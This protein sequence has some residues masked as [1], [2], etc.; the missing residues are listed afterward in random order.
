MIPKVPRQPSVTRQ[1]PLTITPRPLTV[2][3]WPLN[4][5][6]TSSLS[7]NYYSS[8]IGYA[9]SAPTNP[10][11]SNIGHAAS[12]ITTGPYQPNVGSTTTTI[13]AGPIQYGVGH[14]LPT[15]TP[16]PPQVPTH[17]GPDPITMKGSEPLR[18]LPDTNTPVPAVPVPSL[19]TLSE[20]N[21]QLQGR[22][23]EL[24]NYIAP[25]YWTNPAQLIYSPSDD[26]QMAIQIYKMTQGSA[27]AP[28]L[29]L[30]FAFFNRY[31]GEVVHR[32]YEHALRPW[33]P[34]L[35]SH[36]GEPVCD[37]ES[38][39]VPAILLYTLRIYDS[40]MEK[41]EFL[42]DGL[43]RKGIRDKSRGYDYPSAILQ[44]ISPYR[45]EIGNPKYDKVPN[46]ADRINGAGPLF[47][48]LLPFECRCILGESR[49]AIRISQI[50][51][52]YN[53]PTVPPTHEIDSIVIDS[54]TPLEPGQGR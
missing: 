29:M 44:I 18:P 24:L 16:S 30:P 22:L 45:V 32:T 31:T 14:A 51:L 53:E 50:N 33:D 39:V 9:S 5:T 20:V 54:N 41:M 21:K 47:S 36:P 3:A 48:I 19:S 6:K 8:K 23:F 1:T 7:G 4:K 17:A 2:R 35:S 15:V 34:W 42:F 38:L 13:A 40:D 46:M 11:Q 52:T 25:N 26:L 28:N 27:A 10:Y 37:I 12:T 49:P 43:Y